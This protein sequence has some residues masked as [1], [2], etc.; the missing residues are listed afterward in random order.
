[1]DLVMLF[2]LENTK[3]IRKALALSAF[4]LPILVQYF[5]ISFLVNLLSIYYPPTPE[6]QTI[7]KRL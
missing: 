3:P 2:I 7:T 1:M 5:Q 6:N 4:A